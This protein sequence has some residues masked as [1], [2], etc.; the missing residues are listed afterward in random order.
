[1]FEAGK[2]EN[3]IWKTFKKGCADYGLLN[4]GDK[5]LVALSGGKDSLMMLDLLAKQSRIF[6]P[7]I[8]IEAAHVTMDNIP[9]ESDKGFLADY[10]RQRQNTTQ[11]LHKNIY[12]RI[13]YKID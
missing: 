13:S 1:M 3:K 11:Q 8:S 9:Y 2:L 12:I 7:A 6:R 10:C 5:I 4:D